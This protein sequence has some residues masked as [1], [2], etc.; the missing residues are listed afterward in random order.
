M[1]VYR[2]PASLSMHAC[3][4]WGDKGGEGPHCWK[5][6]YFMPMPRERF[7]RGARCWSIRGKEASTISAMSSWAPKTLED[8]DEEVFFLSDEEDL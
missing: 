4:F 8:D 5:C 7:E 2:C 6:W 3:R 1:G